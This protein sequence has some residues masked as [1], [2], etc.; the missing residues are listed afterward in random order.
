MEKGVLVLVP[1]LRS[2][3]LVLFGFAVLAVRSQDSPLTPAMFIFGDSL[4]DGGN[5]NY[6]PSIARADY[7]PYGIDFGFPT[8]RFCNGLTV[9]DYGA[10]LLGLPLIPPYLS[11][12]S[13][14]MNIL[15]GVNY[16]SAAAGILDES[17]KNYGARITFD[18]QI[19]LFEKTVKHDLPPLFQSL[20]ALSRY[21]AKSV[22][23]VTIGS[24]DYINNYLNPT[25][26]NS[27]QIYS[28]EEF[29]DLLIRAL[30]QQL[31]KLYG[32]GARKMVLGGVGPIGCIPDQLSKG[33][34]KNGCIQRINDLAVLF[35]D[36]LMR[37]ASSLNSTLPGSFFVYHNIFDVFYDMVINPNEYEF[38]VP[39][40]AC[41]GNG[42]YGGALTCL[43]L[44]LPCSSR[45]Q[46]IFWDS[47]HPTQAV[48]AIVANRGYSK[49]ATDC[50]PISVYQLAQI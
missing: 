5:N 16:A 28:G 37:L 46:Y 18:G 2:L 10:R 21:L 43:P 8:G 13:K 31:T 17:G 39:N 41:C 7:L 12:L 25:I 47:F 30:S 11:P 33:N 6:I 29:A 1:F 32:L 50:Y 20:E 36:R 22:F 48:N 14:G 26:S 35:N 24:N 23:I 4:N 34:G 15:K 45:N 40:K 27:S 19:A 44:Q 42:R 38:T 3:S 49:S 9:V